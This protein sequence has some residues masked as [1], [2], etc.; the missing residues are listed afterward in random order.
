MCGSCIS[1]YYIADI[2]NLV[3]FLYLMCVY[4]CMGVWV[5]VYG[6]GGVERMGSCIL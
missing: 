4:R 5:G 6:E 3:R 2:Y 1:A